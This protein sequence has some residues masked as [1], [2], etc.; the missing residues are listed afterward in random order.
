MVERTVD[1]LGRIDILVNNAAWQDCGDRIE[2]VTAEEWRRIFATNIEAMFHLSKAAI[3]RM[4][5]RR[6]HH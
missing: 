3:P 1:E 4:A 6:H 2:E 5:S